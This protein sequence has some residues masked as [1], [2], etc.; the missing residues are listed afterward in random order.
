ME[1]TTS[2]LTHEAHEDVLDVFRAARCI[3]GGGPGVCLAWR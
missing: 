3:V 2:A 1:P